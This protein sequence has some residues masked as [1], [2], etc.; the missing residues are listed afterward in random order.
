MNMRRCQ[1]AE[2]KEALA[3]E[4]NLSFVPKTV[5]TSFIVCQM[6]RTD[7]ELNEADLGLCAPQP[8]LWSDGGRD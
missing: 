5:G 2:F 6:L 4:C 7:L 8:A 3:A 1:G